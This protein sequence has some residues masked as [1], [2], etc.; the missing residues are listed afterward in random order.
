MRAEYSEDSALY[1]E[2]T[3]RPQ[4]RLASVNISAESAHGEKF[5]MPN[6]FVW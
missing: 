3:N 4:S 5:I 1:G 2:F 6:H